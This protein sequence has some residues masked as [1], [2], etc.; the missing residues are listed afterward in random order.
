MKRVVPGIFRTPFTP[1]G[2]PSPLRL[3]TTPVMRTPLESLQ[4]MFAESL[5]GDQRPVL[6][7]LQCRGR[8]V[9]QA[10][11]RADSSA[12]VSE[13]TP[14]FSGNDNGA[15]NEHAHNLPQPVDL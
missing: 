10:Q 11:G 5:E 1:G 14:S 13:Q 7:Q 12:C 15:G 9:D 4:R 8:G 2:R 6:S 3:N